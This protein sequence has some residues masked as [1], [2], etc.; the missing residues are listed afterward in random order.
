MAIVVGKIAG[1]YA[2]TTLTTSENGVE[3]KDL[4]ADHFTTRER[5]KIIL[6]LVRRINDLGARF[7]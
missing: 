7:K 6:R 5:E 3:Y 2:T 1:I 4:G